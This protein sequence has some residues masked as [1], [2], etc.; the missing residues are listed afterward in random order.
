[1]P[2]ASNGSRGGETVA[3]TPRAV[4]APRVAGAWSPWTRLAGV[5]VFAAAFA[6]VEGIVVYYLGKLL[7][8][9]PWDAARRGFTFP[10]QYL[11]IERSREAA[12]MVMLLAVGYLAGRTRL[13]KLAYWLFAF[14]LWDTCYYVSL[15]VLEHWPRS[16]ADRDLLFLIPSPWWGPVWE[17][18]SISVVFMVAATMMLAR[19]R[20]G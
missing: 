15:R 5:G 8:G 12:T 1:M 17:P 9:G 2:V 6:V 19:G 7:G 13:Q 10:S 3:P 18:V 14:G 20:Q 16:L 11:T 4:S